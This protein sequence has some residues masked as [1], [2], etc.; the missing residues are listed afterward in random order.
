MR[1]NGCR[2]GLSVT[3]DYRLLLRFQAS[4]Y[5]E[6]AIRVAADEVAAR[7]RQLMLDEE[8][9]ERSNV[10]A[11]HPAPRLWLTDDDR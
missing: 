1:S 7:R 3:V 4:R 9:P 11:L 5:L 2:Y 10:L 8:R 6:A